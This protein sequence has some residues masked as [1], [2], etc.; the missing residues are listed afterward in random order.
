MGLACYL[1][2]L[3]DLTPEQLEEACREATR[4]AEQFPK[5]GHIRNAVRSGRTGEFLGPPLLMYPEISQEERDEAIKECRKQ[6]GN[7][8]AKT[9]DSLKPKPAKTFTVR[10]STLNLEGQKRVLREKGFLK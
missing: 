2:A 6:M 5:P 4:T 7:E 10:P 8:W 1:E 3:S 9:L